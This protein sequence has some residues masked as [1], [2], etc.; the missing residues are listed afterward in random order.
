MAEKIDKKETKLEAHIVNRTDWQGFREETVYVKQPTLRERTQMLQYPAIRAV[1]KMITY[2]ILAVEPKIISDDEQQKTFLNEWFKRYFRRIATVL[3]LKGMSWGFCAGEKIIRSAKIN[4]KMYWFVEG[5]IAPEPYNTTLIYSKDTSL[6]VDGFTWSGYRIPREDMALYIFQGDEIN[7]PYGVSIPH[8]VYWAWIQLMD[9]WTK[10]AIY[11]DFK[12]IPPVILEYPEEMT[13]DGKGGQYDVNEALA[14]AKLKEVRNMLGI[15]IP[16]RWNENKQEWEKLWDIREME[17]SE[18]TTAFIDSI[19]KLESLIFI[20]SLVPKRLLEQDMKAGAYALVKEQADFFYVILQSRIEEFE[21]YLRR[22]I[23]DPMLQ[24]NFANVNVDF[25]LELSD[26]LKTWYLDIIKEG[27]KL[28]FVNVDFDEILQ[29]AGIPHKEGPP[30]P[31]V[32]TGE[33]EGAK[34]LTLQERQSRKQLIA[35][36]KKI[37]QEWADATNPKLLSLKNTMYKDLRGSLTQLQ[38][39]MGLRIV[40]LFKRKKWNQNELAKAVQVPRSIFANTI[41]YLTEAY[42]IGAKAVVTKA[43]KVDRSTKDI[44]KPTQQAQ[45]KLNLLTTK[46]NGMDLIGG[47]PEL[48]E[49]RLFYAVMNVAHPDE[50]LNQFNQTFNNYLDLTLPNNVLNELNIS[51]QLGVYDAV[52]QLEIRELQKKKEQGA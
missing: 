16:K 3:L 19:N 44:E 15:T 22:W 33:I 40:N 34:K 39:K 32:E 46:F 28:G 49:D 31:K 50:V 45:K 7:R 26:E 1:V 6:Q 10:W 20:A 12:A 30:E 8:D 27:L 43:R 37:A 11:K 48:L 25:N 17:I 42:H 13:D 21:E 5:I 9:D 24:Q 4:N 41:N 2:T 52:K 18:K 23:I 14:N 47:Q 29:R 36:K 38:G 51:S 35:E